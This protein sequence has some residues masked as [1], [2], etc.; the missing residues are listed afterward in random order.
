MCFM[1]L[2]AQSGADAVTLTVDASTRL[3]LGEQDR[4]SANLFGVTAFE[5]FTSVVADPDYRARVQAL[6]PGCVRLPAP[7][8]WFAPLTYDPGWYGTEEAAAQFEQTLLFGARYPLGRFLPL[9]RQ[10]GIEPMCSLGSPPA[11]LTQEGTPNPSDF[12]Q[13]AEY[14]AAFVGLWKRFD[15]GLR[16]VQVWNE[17]NASWFADPRVPGSGRSEAELHIEMANTV[18][19]AIKV[20][21]PD[22]LVGGPVLCWPPAWPPSQEGQQPWYTWQ[23]WTIPWLEQTRDIIDFFDFHDYFA[24]PDEL[25][26]QLEM[27]ANQASLTQ[28]RR[29]P[30]W[31]TESNRML[32]DQELVDPAAVWAKRVLPYE[33]WLLQG[34]LPQADKVDGNLVHDLGARGFAVI[35]GPLDEPGP[36][37]WLLWIL[38]DLRGVRL[39]ADSPDPTLPVC[40]TLEDDRLTVV[41]FNDAGH[42]RA[43]DLD[44]AVPAGYWTGPTLRA[45]GPLPGGGGGPVTVDAE[46]VR[47]GTHSRVRL[48]LPGWTTASVELRMDRFAQPSGVRRIEERFGDTTLQFLKRE[49]SVRARIDASGIPG[50]AEVRLRIGLLGPEGNEPLWARL[51]GHDL[52]VRPVPLQEIPV[53]LADMGPS[54]TIELGLSAPVDNPRLALGFISLVVQTEDP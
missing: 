9:A 31:I 52:T 45:I 35:S 53:A 28:S 50:G 39:V 26:V 12:D 18:A 21:H 1:A 42:E 19:R 14:C 44:V 7:V 32:A 48:S 25:A 51:D 20:A 13:W 47:D 10:M 41:V 15:P 4:L 29:L 24:E 46:A 8:S 54:A 11:Y 17:P 49:G 22:V 36:L 43:V 34:L 6:R 5:G 30:I 37:Y 3:Q 27:L 2:T 16:L 23:L 33:R 40:A 38:R